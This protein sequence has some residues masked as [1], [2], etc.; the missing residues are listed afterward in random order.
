MAES[1]DSSLAGEMLVIRDVGFPETV[2]APD[3]RR[4]R[5]VHTLNSGHSPQ[6]SGRSPGWISRDIVPCEART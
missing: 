4:L 2:G 1:I 6:K 5:S 3:K